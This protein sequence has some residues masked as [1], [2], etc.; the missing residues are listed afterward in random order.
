MPA[1]ADKIDY[2]LERL[3]RMVQQ[4]VLLFQLREDCRCRFPGAAAGPE[5]NGGENGG[6]RR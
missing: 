6:W 5:Q 3:E 2:R 1:G 4:H